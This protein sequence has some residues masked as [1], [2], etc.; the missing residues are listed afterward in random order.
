MRPHCMV[1]WAL[2]IHRLQHVAT[3]TVGHNCPCGNVQDVR[4]GWQHHD[5]TPS[6]YSSCFS[7][8][9]IGMLLRSPSLWDAWVARL[10]WS[11]LALVFHARWRC[12]TWARSRYGRPVET[13]DCIRSGGGSSCRA[14]APR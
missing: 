3:L 14:R 13:S 7:H 2:W 12:S 4:F 1:G 9:L 10:L 5:H 11:S 8:S 6:I